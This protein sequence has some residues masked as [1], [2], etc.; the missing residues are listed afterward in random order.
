MDGYKRHYSA[1]V[2]R[3]LVYRSGAFNPMSVAD[4]EKLERLKLRNDY[5]LRPAAEATIRP[6]Q[7]PLRI[8]HTLLNVLADA[9]SAAPADRAAQGAGAL[10]CGQPDRRVEAERRRR[11]RGAT[12]D[13]RPPG[14]IPRAPAGEENGTIGR[15]AKEGKLGCNAL[16]RA[17]VRC[18]PLTLSTAFPTLGAPTAFRR[19]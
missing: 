6:D 16:K 8:R 10:Q 13:T 4:K 9:K 2:V 5:D 15:T 17:T 18:R 7:L 3:G 19:E 11:K 12:K 1:T 14:R